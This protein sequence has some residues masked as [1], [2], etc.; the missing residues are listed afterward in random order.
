MNLKRL[1]AAGLVVIVLVLAAAGYDRYIV[2][3][4][5]VRSR[6]ARLVITAAPPG[7]TGKP[8][9]A[10][11]VTS[12]SNPFAEFKA[13]A[14]RFPAETG[15][16]SVSWS[17]PSS[18]DD[19]ATLLASLVP[20]AADARTLAAQA[21]SQFL[22]ADSFKSES[23]VQVERLVVPGLAGG[24]AALYRAA[25]SAKT[26]PVVSLE[27]RVGRVEVLEL[28]GQTGPPNA[29]ISTA[30]T[31]A[32]SEVSHL[33]AVEPG[34]ALEVTRYPPVATLIYWVVAA[35]LVMA[36]IAA[37]LAIRRSRRRRAEATARTA[38]RQ[39]LARG[40]KIARRQGRR[41]R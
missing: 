13:V 37:P 27:Y 20:S 25:G 8:A 3:R 35:G 41:R 21:S 24:Q 7:Y 32:R 6:L 34:F 31:L 36:M 10:S 39:R 19:S 12:S 29:A 2:Q 40:G 33:D 1:T 28:V 15:A 11:R 16:Y 38:R 22:G 18:A 23:Y 9:A 14:K 26:P 30:E 17:S 4:S 5:V